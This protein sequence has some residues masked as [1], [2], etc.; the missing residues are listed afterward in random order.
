MGRKNK[1]T[2][3]S[4]QITQKFPT[5]LPND[6]ENINWNGFI[7][8]G[9]SGNRFL[10]IKRLGSGSYSSVWLTY[11]INNFKSNKSIKNFYAIKIHNTTDELAGK[12]ELLVNSHFK[13]LQTPNVMLPMDEFVMVR[14]YKDEELRHICI[15]MDLMACSTYDLI[16]KGS[17]KKG[18]PVEFVRKVTYDTLVALSDIHKMNLI[19]SDVKPENILLDGVSNTDKELM[20]KVL[21]KESILSLM[22]FIKKTEPNINTS[23]EET[24]SDETDFDSDSSD[25]T[26]DSG[27]IVT[28]DSYG[29]D[30]RSGLV[31]SEDES[32]DSHNIEDIMFGGLEVDKKYIDNPHVCLTDMGTCVSPDSDKRKKYIQ[33]KYYRSPEILLRLGYDQ[34]SDMW[35]LGCTIYEL[36]TG[37]IL[38]NPDNQDFQRKKYQLELMTRKLGTIPK[39]M[40]EKSHHKEVYFTD[41]CHLKGVKK[42]STDK[43]F[44]VLFNTVND[45]TKNP[46]LANQFLDIVFQLLRYDSNSRPNAD[47]A[48]AHPL[49]EGLSVGQT[50]KQQNTSD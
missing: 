33:T 21:R 7:A 2:T 22:K 6:E 25:E 41:N 38:F 9:T 31:D 47:Q 39:E 34:K 8:N 11:R 3:K 14:R 30:S 29:A 45:K 44:H 16:K 1:R 32:E 28:E 12:K 42:I 50:S 13:K 17:Y 36:L 48:L 40:I 49:F 27:S 23:D 10:L 43:T 46:K 19:H 4:K 35:A 15:V 24:D 26:D 20:E 18:Y 5:F 37:E